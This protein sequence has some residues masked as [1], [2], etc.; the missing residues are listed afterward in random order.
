M[1]KIGKDLKKIGIYVYATATGCNTKE[2]EVVA[3]IFLDII[4]KESREILRTRK[5]EK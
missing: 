4:G 3:A 5:V 1:I 2:K